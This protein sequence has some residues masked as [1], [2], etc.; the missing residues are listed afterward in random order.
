MESICEKVMIAQIERR[1]YQPCHIDVRTMPEQNA[2]RINQEYPAIGGECPEYQR[3]IGTDDAIEDAGCGALLN[4]ACGFART[5][6]K[7]LPVDN[8]PRAVGHV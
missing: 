8:G 5:D 2:A 7:P 1:G 3:R 6:R 4:E